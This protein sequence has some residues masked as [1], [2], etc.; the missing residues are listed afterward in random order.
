MLGNRAVVIFV[1]LLAMLAV[2][3]GVVFLGLW[4][5]HGAIEPYGNPNA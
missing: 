3:V 5:L 2:I 1:F 4:I